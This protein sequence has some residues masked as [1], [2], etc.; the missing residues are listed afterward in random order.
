[1]IEFTF[2]PKA[3]N[4]YTHTI[5]TEALK[6]REFLPRE[7]SPRNGSECVRKPLAKTSGLKKVKSFQQQK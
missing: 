1:E 2:V 7:G 4:I 6:R 3:K 5:A